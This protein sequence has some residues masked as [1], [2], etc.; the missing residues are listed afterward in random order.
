[1]FFVNI[2]STLTKAKN[3]N[4]G[5]FINLCYGL[6]YLYYFIFLNISESSLFRELQKNCGVVFQLF[7]SEIIILHIMAKS[8][9]L[10]K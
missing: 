6:F 1:M 7:N 9:Q 2:I 8:Q 4:K 3:S 5:T 10:I